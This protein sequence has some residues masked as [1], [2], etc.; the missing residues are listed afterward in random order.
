MAGWPDAYA[1]R[2]H[3]TGAPQLEALRKVEN[4]A[5]FHQRREGVFAV[6]VGASG[7]SALAT[8]AGETRRSMTRSPASV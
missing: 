4:G 2:A 7:A 8:H 6:S 1:V 5:A 3:D